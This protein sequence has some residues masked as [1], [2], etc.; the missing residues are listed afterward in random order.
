MTGNTKVWRAPLAG[1][2]SVAMLATMGVAAGTAS[3]ATNNPSAT[4]ESSQSGA[5]KLD[6]YNVTVTLHA[7]SPA[8]VK[9]KATVDDTTDP[10]LAGDTAT[11][12]LSQ[13]DSDGNGTLDELYSSN[14]WKLTVPNGDSFTGWY[15]SPDY[16]SEKFDFNNTFVGKNLDLYAHY[17]EPD[18]LVNLRFETSGNLLD[19]STV[20]DGS[21]VSGTDNVSDGTADSGLQFANV[22][23]GQYRLTVSKKDGKIAAW[24]LPQDKVG[25]YKVVKEWK[26]DPSGDAASGYAK[27]DNPTQDVTTDQLTSGF[28]KILTYDN[29]GQYNVAVVPQDPGQNAVTVKYRIKP[30]GTTPVAAWRDVAYGETVPTDVLV[31]DGADYGYVDQWYYKPLASGDLEKLPEGYKANA[32]Y[33]DLAL[34]AGAAT[35]AMK[36]TYKTRIDN[37]NGTDKF[38]TAGIEYVKA[39][40]KATAPSLSRDGGYTL[41]GWSEDPN[42]GGKQYDFSAGVYKDTVLYAQWNTG[43]ATVRYS[44]NY[45]NQFKDQSYATGDEF[46]APA[47][48]RSGR[49]FLGWYFI[50]NV[51]DGKISFGGN[52]A[53]PFTDSS[54]PQRGSEFYKAWNNA[55]G[56]VVGWNT[57]RD[58]KTFVGTG[59]WLKP[60]PNATATSVYDDGAGNTAV[61]IPAG[62]KLRINAAGNLEFLATKKT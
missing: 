57:G 61:E 44:Y 18:D 11:F 62:A 29:S 48:T 58:E 36:V 55:N 47:P 17:A 6:S 33:K 43:K 23:G 40:D 31:K 7:N 19:T 2:A 22:Q 20:Y 54:L 49:V 1:L 46:T 41:S 35:D 38:V 13:F 42:F 14:D 51:T 56:K 9:A 52:A 37:S 8:N 32:N 59:A 26:A 53:N 30:N 10:E 21:R 45:A 34:Y 16:G 28:A 15:T 50:G 27:P 5:A 12:D 60:V 25:D 4:P 3:A 24:E 39:G